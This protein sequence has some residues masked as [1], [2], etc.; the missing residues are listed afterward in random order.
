MKTM[1]AADPTY[2]GNV[3]VEFV[4]QNGDHPFIEVDLEKEQM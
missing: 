2:C 3:T 4:D 1:R